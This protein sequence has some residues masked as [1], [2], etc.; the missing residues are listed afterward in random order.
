MQRGTYILHTSII[1][2]IFKR[3]VF[4]VKLSQNFF[5]V[6]IKKKYKCMLITALT[7]SST[8]THSTKWLFQ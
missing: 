6:F 2:I 5:L 1:S 7:F 4:Q 8:C 3:V